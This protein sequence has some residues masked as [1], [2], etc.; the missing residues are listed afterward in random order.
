M[1]LLESDSG[2]ILENE[3][4]LAFFG[5]KNS[6]IEILRSEFPQYLFHRTKQIHSD[7]FI[8]TFKNSADYTVEADAQYTF[9][10]NLALCSITA[11]CV[12]VL[13]YNSQENSVAAIH[14]GWRGI[15]NQISMKTIEG[16]CKKKDR[17]ECLVFVGP[18]IQQQSFECDLDVKDKLLACIP[19]ESKPFDEPDFV[20]QYTKDGVEKFKVDLHK[21]LIEQLKSLGIPS[22]N[23]FSL[24]IDT[25]K[26]DRFH[27]YRRDKAEAGRQISF[28]LQK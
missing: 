21:I 3:S 13:V 1:R 20:L 19:H 18:H 12:P 4:V 6:Q 7:K 9:E 2:Y 14:A 8:Q 23:V 24:Y 27:S 16:F 25:V 17:N 15:E 11:D 26:D 22:E 28:I 5:K 10:K